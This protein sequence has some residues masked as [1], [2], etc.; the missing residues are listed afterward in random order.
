MLKRR[1][2]RRG[3]QCTTPLISCQ[4]AREAISALVD[5]E[6]PPISEEIVTGHLA[7]C[8]ACQAFRRSVVSLT[9]EIRVRA[10]DP[11]PNDA[12]EILELLGYSGQALTP[13]CGRAHSRAER[14]R[15]SWARASQWAA[16]IVP[17]GL[18]VPA[19]ALGVFAHIHIV[20]SHVLTPCTI[21]L[22]HVRG[23]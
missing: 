11:V 8:Q 15:F 9:R 20:P 3:T 13:R 22:H 17:L 23:G 21:G 5:R 18:A 12:G 14:R 10:F 2:S 16:G 1:P 19:L 6:T 7:Q 4:L